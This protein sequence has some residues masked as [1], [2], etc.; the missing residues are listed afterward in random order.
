MVTGRLSSAMIIT[1]HLVLV[2]IRLFSQTHTIHLITGKMAITS[3]HWNV[4]LHSGMIVI[5]HQSRSNYSRTSLLTIKNNK[6]LFIEGISEETH[7]FLFLYDKNFSLPFR[8]TLCYN[9]SKLES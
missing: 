4:G 7:L 6:K 1:A 8:Q 3:I 2:M 9:N 5:S